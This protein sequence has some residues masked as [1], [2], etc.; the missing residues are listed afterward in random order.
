MIVSA[1]G[2]EQRLSKIDTK[3]FTCQGADVFYKGRL[4]AVLKSTELGYDD[5]KI[6]REMTYEITD[7]KYQDKALS[8]V[9]Y[10]H[11]IQP[12]YDVEVE[13]CA[14]KVIGPDK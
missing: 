1:C 13:V 2:T 4:V 14:T 12:N 5:G 8:L 3:G 11:D 10:L 6:V 7:V 9:K